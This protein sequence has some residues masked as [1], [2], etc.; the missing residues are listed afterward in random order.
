[1]AE[2]NAKLILAFTVMISGV[3]AKLTRFSR[4][5][6]GATA[7]EYALIVGLITIAIFTAVLLLGDSIGVQIAKASCAVQGKDYPCS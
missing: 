7:V 5:E 4:D 3:Q 2:M 6:D 1:M